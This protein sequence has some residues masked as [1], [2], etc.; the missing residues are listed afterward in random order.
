MPEKIT[1]VLTGA[2]ARGAFQAGALAEIIPAL[3]DEGY[4]PSVFLGTSAG[5]INAALWGAHSD[6]SPRACG[7]SVLALWR[8]IGSDDI[9]ANPGRTALL[10][11]AP[12]V[13][14]SLGGRGGGL[15][16][17]LDTSPLRRT[18]ERLFDVDRLARNVAAGRVGAVGVTTTRLAPPDPGGPRT[19][20]S[21][22]RTTIFADS[23]SLD[24]SRMA[25][26]DLA[27]DV[28]PGRITREQVIASAAIPIAFPPQWIGSPAAAQGWHIDGGVRL[29]APLAPA[30]RL[31]ADRVLVIAALAT[32]YGD[33]LPPSS[34]PG[35]VPYI[36]DTGAQLVHSALG[37]RLSEDLRALHIRNRMIT[38]ASEAQSP[39]TDATGR[40][41]RPVPVMTISPEPGAL[42]AL[43]EEVLAEKRTGIL[44]RFRE[45]SATTLDA[46]LRAVGEGPGARELF[47]YIFFDDAYFDR[48]IE[49]GRRAAARA[50]A[51]GWRTG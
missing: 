38:R 15:P 3:V 4:D 36:T 32:E 18:A 8:S 17:L 34:I 33:P 47:S 19:G 20:P 42:A 10:R 13:L 22:A 16:S 26:P 30:L 21:Y 35:A 46:L 40:P 27:I 44:G 7:D 45:S 25:D 12:R 2:A 49:L 31:G 24:V 50:L 48:Q 39:L 1:V 43:A 51:A 28:A 41:E 11:N 5:G 14:L 9:F 29:N 37:D 23:A 6:L